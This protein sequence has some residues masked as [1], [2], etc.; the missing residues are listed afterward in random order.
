MEAKARLT[1]AAG[2][3]EFTRDTEMS[4]ADFALVALIFIIFSIG[5]VGSLMVFPSNIDRLLAW[6]KRRRA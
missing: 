6:W 3:H 2:G 4:E 5:A 1:E